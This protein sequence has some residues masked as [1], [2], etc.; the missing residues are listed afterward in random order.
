MPV[1]CS[2]AGGGGTNGGNLHDACSQ[3]KFIN[4]NCFTDTFDVLF[5]SVPFRS[6]GSPLCETCPARRARSISLAFSCREIIPRIA[7]AFL[8]LFACL[9][10]PRL[11]VDPCVRGLSFNTT[12][13]FVRF[14][15][16]VEWPPQ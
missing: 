16:T 8:V 6:G 7:R 15:L 1:A 13:L 10:I 4:A 11:C 2:R 3:L 5:C 9:T 14:F 12:T